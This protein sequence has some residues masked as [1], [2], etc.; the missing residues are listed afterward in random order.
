MAYSVGITGGI[1]SGKSTICRLFSFLG[2]PV[3]DADRRAKEL[4]QQDEALRGD[5]LEAFGPKVYDETG[6]LNRSWLASQVFVDPQALQTLNGLVHPAVFRD[7]A[8]WLNAQQAAPY[9]IREAALL[10]ESGSYRMLDTVVTVYAPE[11]LRVKRVMKRDGVEEAAV[12][13]RMKNQ[14]SDERKRAMAEFTVLNDGEHPVIP[15][16]LELHRLFLKR[17]SDS[18]SV[19]G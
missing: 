1:G 5:L 7:S 13:A 14:W 15:Q 19:Q 2:V 17:A 12:R 9:T 16:V 10:F 8:N 11:G 3:Y 18:T 6:K 4:M